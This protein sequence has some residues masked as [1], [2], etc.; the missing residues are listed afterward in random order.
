[1]SMSNYFVQTKTGV[2]ADFIFV[3]M[4]SCSSVKKKA[5]KLISEAGCPNPVFKRTTEKLTSL[6]LREAGYTDKIVQL[7]SSVHCILINPMTK[8]YVNLLD[9]DT[10]AIIQGIKDIYGK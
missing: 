3:A 10:D 2:T 9:K 1:M 4:C 5:I 8:T 6:F 7:R